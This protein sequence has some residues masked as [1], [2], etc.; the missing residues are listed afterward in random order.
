MLRA[1]LAAGGLT[2]TVA[3]SPILAAADEWLNA[4]RRRL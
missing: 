4:W 3:L 2:F 1:N